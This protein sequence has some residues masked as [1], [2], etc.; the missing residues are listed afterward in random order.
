V[1]ENLIK[2]SLQSVDSREGQIH[3]RAFLS[4]SKENVHLEIEDNGKGVASTAARKLF[5][6]GFATKKRGW[7]MGLTLVKRIVEEYHTGTISLS[8]S[9]PGETVFEII[10]PI[11]GRNKD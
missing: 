6:P 9:R 8:R 2:N 7:G 11:S 4:N 10:L 5:R 3:I 1:L